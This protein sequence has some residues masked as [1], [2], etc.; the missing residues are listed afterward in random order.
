MVYKFVNKFSELDNIDPNSFNSNSYDVSVN[1][2]D[3]FSNIFAYWLGGRSNHDKRQISRWKGIVSRLVELMKNLITIQFLLLLQKFC[4]I[5][6]KILGWNNIKWRLIFYS[7]DRYSDG[8]D[9][10]STIMIL[11]DFDRAKINL[12]NIHL[13]KI[14]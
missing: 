3:G 13:L 5:W 6:A 7:Q 8:D 11:I 2:Y 14:L 9:K 10:W 12:K 1:E 4:F